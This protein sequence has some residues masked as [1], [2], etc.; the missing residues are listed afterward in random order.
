MPTLK[1]FQWVQN[2]LDVIETPVL[3][4]GCRAPVRTKDTKVEWHS[5]RPLFKPGDY[6]GTDMQAGKDVDVLCDLTNCV[7]SQFGYQFGECFKAVFCLST[8]EHVREPWLIA[9]TIS[10]LLEPGGV[11]F[12]SVPW[13]WRYHGHPHDYWR[14]SPHAVRALFP[15]FELLRK[16][17]VIWQGCKQRAVTDIR[18]TRPYADRDKQTL[19]QVTVNM[20]LRKA[21]T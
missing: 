16:R 5:L 17:S 10:E 19:H 1:Q 4:V 3:D 21:T 13:V 18:L 9:E 6:I 8:L 12:V 2:N 20:V 7:L 15:D 14:M 11:L